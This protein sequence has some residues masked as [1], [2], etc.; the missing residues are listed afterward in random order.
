MSRLLM[1]WLFWN[2]PAIFFWTCI[3]LCDFPF[4]FDIFLYLCVWIQLKPGSWKLMINPVVL[5]TVALRGLL[6]KCLILSNS[7]VSMTWSRMQK[8]ISPQ[9]LCT[10]VLWVLIQIWCKRSTT[11]L[12]N[13]AWHHHKNILCIS[14]WSLRVA[15]RLL[16]LWVLCN[17]NWHSGL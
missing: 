17:A 12:C 5:L 11:D 2:I 14:E 10:Q 8:R 7:V 16:S 9:A 6:E 4:P 1:V 3:E 15:F 13:R